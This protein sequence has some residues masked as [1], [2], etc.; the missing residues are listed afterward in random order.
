MANRGLMTRIPIWGRVLG[1]IALVLVGVLTSTMFLGVA[2][3][4]GR[5]GSGGHGSGETQMDGGGQGS[6]DS[7]GHGRSGDSGGHG[8]SGDETERSDHNKGQ[9]GPAPPAARDL[10]AVSAQVVSVAMEDIAFLP[11]E[12]EVHRGGRA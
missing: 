2:D 4:G 8:R 10:S 1:I 11:V 5:G 3:V 6:G 12:A 9:G 7:G